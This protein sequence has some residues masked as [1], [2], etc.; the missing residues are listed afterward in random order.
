[1]INNYL[2]IH[3][4][5]ITVNFLYKLNNTVC[6]HAELERLGNDPYYSLFF[7]EENQTL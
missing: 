5:G 2:F 1:M 4:L 3:D 6:F 7:N